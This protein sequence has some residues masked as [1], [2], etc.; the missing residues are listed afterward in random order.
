M[1]PYFFIGRSMHGVGYA[2]IFVYLCVGAHYA[3]VCVCARVC[4]AVCVCMSMSANTP[5]EYLYFN[6]KGHF[7]HSV[8]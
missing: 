5:D 2:C 1:I 4:I 7:S 3:C 6:H 8:S